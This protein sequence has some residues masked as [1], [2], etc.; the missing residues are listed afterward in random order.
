LKEQ[1][2]IMQDEATEE[3]NRLYDEG[4]YLL[5]ERYRGH[6]DRI[7][8]EVKFLANQFEEDPQNRAFGDSMEKLFKDLGQDENGKPKFKPHLVTDITNVILPTIFEEVRYVPIPRIEVS[9]P[10]ADVVSVVMC[11]VM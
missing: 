3:W 9:D 2:F 6:T 8:D 7:V 5:R 4:R 10:A 11:V 1:G